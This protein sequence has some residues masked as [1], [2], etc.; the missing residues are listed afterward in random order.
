MCYVMIPTLQQFLVVSNNI[1]VCMC[2][3]MMPTLQQFLVVAF[4]HGLQ[5]FEKVFLEHEVHRTDKDEW[6]DE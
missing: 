1:W 5:T 3:V 2:Y 6:G 4:Y